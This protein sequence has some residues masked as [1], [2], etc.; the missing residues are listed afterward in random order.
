LRGL[1]V[2]AWTTSLG[3]ILVIAIFLATGTAPPTWRPEPPRVVVEQLPDCEFFVCER[4]APIGEPTRVRIPSIGV[5]SSL[6]V[7]RLNRAGA[8]QAPSYER[9][10]WYAD[11][12]V[13]GD[14]GPAVIAGHVDSFRGPAV[15]FRLH[16]LHAGDAVEV[17]R[18]GR[19]LIFRVTGIEQYPKR[20]FPTERVYR[21]T[22][23]AELRLITCGGVFDERGLSYRDNIVVYAA[24]DW[25]SSALPG[26]RKSQ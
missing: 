2:A 16:T 23:D 25:K 12:V 13:P 10:G 14:T 4:A 22:P 5:E 1:E 9:A 18:G 19:W 11:G 8:L 6:E 24:V 7:L 17:E 15:F 26:A 20:D 21:A 3:V